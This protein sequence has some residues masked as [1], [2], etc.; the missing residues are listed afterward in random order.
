MQES[1]YIRIERFSALEKTKL[2][3]KKINLKDEYR[4]VFI[5]HGSLLVAIGD[6]THTANSKN[7][8]FIAPG[9]SFQ[10]LELTENLKGL[11]LIFDTDYFLLCLKNQVK[12]CFYPFF[13]HNRLPVLRLS[14]IQWKNL[15]SIQQKI[16][17]EVQ[18]RENINDDHCVGS[19]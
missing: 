19:T 13:Q 18:N 8:Y 7:I 9:Q 12:L 11:Q 16:A 15:L 2:Q 3:S 6:K 10:V 5:E 1:N 14:I 17:Y 4:I